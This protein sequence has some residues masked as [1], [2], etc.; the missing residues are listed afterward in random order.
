MENRSDRY[1]RE[2]YNDAEL[3]SPKEEEEFIRDTGA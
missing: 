2:R 1:R 3:F